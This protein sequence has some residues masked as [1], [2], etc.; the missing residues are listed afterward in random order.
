MSSVVVLYDKTAG[1]V[2]IVEFDASGAG[3]GLPINEGWRNSWDIAVAGDFFGNG[4]SQILLYDRAAGE[5]E[6]VQFDASGAGEEGFPI[7][8][9][10]NSWDIAVAV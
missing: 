10:R 1:Q 3:H 5:A 8:G 6:I 7:K 2:K 4:K 9:W